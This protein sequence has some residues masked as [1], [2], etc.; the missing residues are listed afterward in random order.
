[1]MAQSKSFSLRPA[2]DEERP[3]LE[4]LYL[5][6]QKPLLEGL[7]DFSEERLIERFRALLVIDD[8]Q[9][10]VSDDQDVGW[11]QLTRGPDAI[12]LAQLHIMPDFQKKRIGTTII[13]RVLDEAS[14][15]G[16]KVTL[17]V[18]KGNRAVSLYKRLGF[19]VND[20]DGVKRYMHWLPKKAV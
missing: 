13:Q 5:S 18:L 11:V 17:A 15:A 2:S 19:K 9:I 20:E 12:D 14:S 16:K 1:M 10:I 8:V 7:P 3:F 6:A 4:R